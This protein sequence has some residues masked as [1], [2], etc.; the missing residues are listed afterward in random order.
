[1]RLSRLC[2]DLEMAARRAAGDEARK[3][4]AEAE[5][6]YAGV[7]IALIAELGVKAD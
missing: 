2:Q 3:L 1:M 6:E 7:H 5:A 4:A